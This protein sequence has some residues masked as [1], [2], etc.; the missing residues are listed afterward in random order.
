MKTKKISGKIMRSILIV[1]FMVV[2]LIGGGVFYLLNS[3]VAN[4]FSDLA[5]LEV[6]SEINKIDQSFVQ[7][8]SAVKGLSAQ[9]AADVDVSKAKR[10][11][12]YLTQYTDDLSE[13]LSAIGKKTAITNSVFVYFNVD[14]FGDA[15]DA[16]VYGDDF[17]RQDVIAKEYY[18]EPHAW[19]DLPIKEGVTQWTFPY[20]VISGEAAGAIVSSYVTPIEKDG[21]I[22]GLVGMDL[23]MADIQASMAE[24]Q[25][26]DT[27]YLYMMTPEGD[28]LVHPAIPWADTDGDDAP[29]TPVNIH[30][31][32]DYKFLTDEMA[33]NESG[34]TKY[35]KDD[36]TPVVAAYSHLKNGWIVAASIPNKEVV[37]VVTNVLIAI[38][39]IAVISIIAA[40][41]ISV[42]VG[43]SITKP[44]NKIVESI[45]HIRDGDFTTIVEVDSNDETRVLA[46]GINEMSKAVK[47]LI[48][49]AKH[50]S[51]DMVDAASNLAAMS[52][53]TNATV[54]QVAITVQE[55]SHGTQETANDAE[56][57][58]TVAG[59]INRQFTI[60]MENS[61]AMKANAELAIEM[62]KTGL[63]ALSTLKDKSEQS[64]ESNV[65]VKG[66]IDN[67]D[68]KANA[69]TD[70]IETITSISEQTNLLALNASIEAARA[71]E[72]G[73]GFAV[74]ADEIRKLAESS[75]E[76][77]DEIRNI[78]V[79]IQGVSQETVTVMNEVSEMNKQQND[80]LIDVNESFDKIFTSVEGI[81]TQIE[82]VTKELTELDTSKNELVGAVNNISAISEETAA[83]TTQV[84]QSMDEQT[85]AV[86]QVALSAE[87]L[88]ELSSELNEKIGFFKV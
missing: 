36:G 52:E 82:V 86:E 38:A 18:D 78:I 19:Y 54:D 46:N 5:E 71:G 17:V 73:R 30:D 24:I 66:A 79:D 41:T 45:A 57:G 39:V 77:A 15:A 74:V 84:E 20:I 40:L 83:A 72:A 8:E 33:S 59:D 43:R 1:N 12:S 67:L 63:E 42:L 29:D 28:F 76:A 22:I 31:L 50:V 61:D 58:A 88:N 26:F 11:F 70:I 10:D 69:I 23:D 35:K 16:W 34:I 64:N 6:K 48:S 49:E 75:S 47:D 65:K 85:K 14:M 3:Q 81:S 7:I 68:E 21:E 27:G 53:E 56:T 87:K 4:E 2:L 44:I 55:I 32:G 51:H 25:V 13:Q 62:N 80:A 37:A 60:L 9:I